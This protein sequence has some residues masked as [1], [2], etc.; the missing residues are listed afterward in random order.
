MI[1]AV[2]TLLLI[3]GT[4]VSTCLT[5]IQNRASACTP[6]QQSITASDRITLSHRPIVEELSS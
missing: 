3:N 2:I 1:V 6:F 5:D 4:V